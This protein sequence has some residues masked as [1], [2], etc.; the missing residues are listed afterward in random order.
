LQVVYLSLIVVQT[1]KFGLILFHVMNELPTVQQD[2]L[3]GLSSISIGMRI[4]PGDFGDAFGF[5][6]GFPFPLGILLKNVGM[7]PSTDASFA[8]CPDAEVASPDCFKES[9]F[10]ATAYSTEGCFRHELAR[11]SL[12]AI[13]DEN[14]SNATT[15]RPN[16]AVAN[17]QRC[18]RRHGTSNSGGNGIIRFSR[19]SSQSSTVIADTASFEVILHRASV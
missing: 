12:H 14:G 17:R 13:A 3:T 19:D 10:A 6:S 1:K 18:G 5:H 4:P 15:A 8:T 11:S 2:R 9:L 7:P 16:I